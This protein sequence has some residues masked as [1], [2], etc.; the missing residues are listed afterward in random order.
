LQTDLAKASQNAFGDVRISARRAV[1]AGRAPGAI[2]VRCAADCRFGPGWLAFAKAPPLAA[3]DLRSAKAHNIRG[4]HWGVTVRLTAGGETRW[5]GFAK[6]AAR[7][8]RS[9]GVPD[10]LI[11][12]V[13]GAVLAQPYASDVLLRSGRLELTGFSRSGAQKAAK[14]LG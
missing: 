11:V 3:A 9:R 2:V 12:V 6:E 5:K 13:D 8:A 14:T 1:L 10:L 4:S 7:N